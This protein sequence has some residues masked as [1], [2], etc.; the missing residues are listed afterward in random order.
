MLSKI[1]E[2]VGGETFEHMRKL[3]TA[4]FPAGGDQEDEVV[5]GVVRELYRQ[6][7]DEVVKRGLPPLPVEVLAPTP[8]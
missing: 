5:A 1:Q 2:H 6:H 3:I 7:G 8:E 4:A